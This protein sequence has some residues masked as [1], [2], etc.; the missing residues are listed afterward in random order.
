MPT[1]A[2]TKQ[3]VLDE[4]YQKHPERFVT[5]S[6]KVALPPDTVAINPVSIELQGTDEDHVNFP[7]LQAVARSI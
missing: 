4:M 1:V 2:P 5:G 3:G 7:T 6:H